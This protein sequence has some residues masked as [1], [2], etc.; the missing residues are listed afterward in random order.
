MHFGIRRLSEWLLFPPKRVGANRLRAAV[1]GKQILITGASYGI[2]EEL[3]YLLA[4]AGAEVLL[5]AR[6]AGKLQ[7]VQ[8]QIV[9]R[10]G[11]AYIF[12][13]DLSDKQQAIAVAQHVLQLWG[14]ADVVV[15]N[16]GKSICRPLHESLDRMHD[17]ERSMAINYFGPVQLLLA[18][19]P[20]L[21]KRKA[22]IINISAI[23]VLLAPAPHW[24]AY[25]SSKT[26]FDQWFRSA[27]AEWMAV[28][29]HVTSVYLPLVRTRMIA[30]TVAYATM[31]AMQS[32]Q[33]A[34]RIARAICHQPLKVAPWWLV[35]GQLGS[36]L[37][38]NVFYRFLARYLKQ[39]PYARQSANTV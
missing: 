8:R 32:R 38:H 15:S 5:V 9:G 35:W 34:I 29:M 6:T 14:G 12:P 19:L 20:A 31:P 22:H 18:L 39:Q 33:A 25:Q 28:G 4:N 37:F 21:E 17:F 16:A 10:G 23:N 11:R 1:S 26:A 7:E 13:A 3:A 27:S 24:A 36:L 2:G 30:P